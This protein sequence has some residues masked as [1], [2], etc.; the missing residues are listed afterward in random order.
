MKKK[1]ISGK[2]I[3]NISV[4]VLCVGMLAY[5]CLSENGLADLLKSAENINLSWLFMAVFC[6]LLN[7][8]LDAYLIYRFTKNNYP[9]YTF[10]NAMK[11]SMVGQFFSCITPFATGGQPMQIY[12]MSRQGVRGGVATSGLMQ[13]FLVYQT[14]LTLYSL[15]AILVRMDYFG[16]HLTPFLWSLAIFGFASQAFVIVGIL[17]FSFSRKLTH[18]L[19][20]L[21]FTLLSKLHIIKDADAKIKGL[22]S[23][24]E[25]FHD[26]NRELYKNRKLLVETYVCTAVQLTTIFIVPYC[27]YRSFN[28]SGESILNMISSQ[29]FVTMASC[30]VPLPGAAGASEFSFMA[31]FGSQFSPETLK[32]AVLVWRFITYYFTMFMSAPFSRLAKQPKDGQNQE[33]HDA[34]NH[35]QAG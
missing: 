20:V 30:F 24:L 13:K 16:Q 31:F 29:A 1:R 19:L 10:R 23:Q 3:F 28:L 5:F 34:D 9:L 14:T 35:L 32:S 22:E 8:A 4:F 21:V 15:L 11:A 26:G 12:L 17:L 6:H 27:V 33:S 18:K 2:T 25:A 7:I